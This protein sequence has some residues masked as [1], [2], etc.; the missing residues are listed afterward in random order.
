MFDSEVLHRFGMACLPI[1]ERFDAHRAK[2]HGRGFRSHVLYE[3]FQERFFSTEV[4]AIS[5][6]LAREY[7]KEII[8]NWGW[9]ASPLVR[10]G[11]GYVSP[12]LERLRKERDAL[13]LTEDWL[14]SSTDER[15]KYELDPIEKIRQTLD[16]DSAS[17][18]ETWRT[19]RRKQLYISEVAS[20][21][22]GYLSRAVKHIFDKAGSK[23]SVIPF[24]L[25]TFAL[26]SQATKLF[27]SAAREIVTAVLSKYGYSLSE[28]LSTKGTLITAV[29]NIDDHYQLRLTMMLS[30]VEVETHLIVC[31][32]KLIK[33]FDDSASIH[34]VPGKT[35][36]IMLW[37][38]FPGLVH[39]LYETPDQLE[40][41]IRE[42]LVAYEIEHDF[43]LKLVDEFCV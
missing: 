6:D 32:P 20:V 11:N 14:E 42:R 34:F 24:G 33:K 1:A 40:V 21:S 26:H 23:G 38:T 41:R 37:D 4:V 12:M 17:F 7:A 29:R 25:A 8:T 5:R 36:E 3:D 22:Q 28:K 15:W 30:P 19:K 18:Q 31:H 9:R 13:G 43:I 2:M 35:F 39:Y 16:S 27:F 10:A